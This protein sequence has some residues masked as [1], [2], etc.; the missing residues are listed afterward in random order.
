MLPK[1]RELMKKEAH[2]FLQEHARGKLTKFEL[3]ELMVQFIETRIPTDDEMRK[4]PKMIVERQNKY[5][6]EPLQLELNI[7]F[8]LSG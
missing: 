6:I 3:A 2:S 8:G 1:D 7:F 5:G 4:Y